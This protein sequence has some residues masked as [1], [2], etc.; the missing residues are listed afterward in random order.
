MDQHLELLRKMSVKEKDEKADYYHRLER[1]AMLIRQAFM[2][3]V[4]P[5]T[6]LVLNAYDMITVNKRI[7]VLKKLSEFE[8]AEALQQIEE[9]QRFAHELLRSL[10]LERSRDFQGYAIT[11]MPTPLF[12]FPVD[13]VDI[14]KS[15]GGKGMTGIN[16]DQQ[17]LIREMAVVLPPGSVV[18]LMK[19]MKVGEFE[20]YQVRTREFDAGPGAKF[21]Y[22]LDARFIQK[23]AQK[24]PEKVAQLPSSQQILKNLKAMQ[25]SSYVRGGSRYQGIPEVDQFFPSSFPLSPAHQ[26]QKNLKGVDCSGL[27]YQ[28]TDSFT[29]RN[30]RQLLT[31]GNAVE[32]EG[33]RID[34]IISLLKPLDLI[35]WAGHVVIVYDQEHSIESRWR[36]NFQ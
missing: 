30:T 34:E 19:K 5:K 8:R 13:Q 22:F 24:P 18:L 2:P 26:K 4:L 3:L 7:A 17:N 32:I 27:L 23:Q 15:F 14:N 29:P 16:L 35:V 6:K 36:A 28:A 10:A 12:R 25:G 33:K 20:Y 9:V 11:K 31:Y 21:G 1:K